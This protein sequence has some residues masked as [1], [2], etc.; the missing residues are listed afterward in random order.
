MTIP[1]RIVRSACSASVCVGG[2]GGGF[3]KSELHMPIRSN[4]S[5]PAL[6]A[7]SSFIGTS[8]YKVHYIQVCR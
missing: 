6:D 4:L 8:K 5:V 1:Y 2:G 7:F 3:V